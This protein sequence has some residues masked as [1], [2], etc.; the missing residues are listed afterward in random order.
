MSDITETDRLKRQVEM[1][2]RK[3]KRL[4]SRA[5]EKNSDEDSLVYSLA[6]LMTLLLI[7]FIL[8]YANSSSDAR[9]IF[10]SV[11]AFIPGL[12][13]QETN[14]AFTLDP[15][16]EFAPEGFQAAAEKKPDPK[17]DETPVSDPP[18]A[19]MEPVIAMLDEKSPA[20]APRPM[21]APAFPVLQGDAA[22]HVGVNAPEDEKTGPKNP[23]AGPPTARSTEKKP[24]THDPGLV[25]GSN[26]PPR[27]GPGVR[28]IQAPGPPNRPGRFR[29][30]QGPG[31]GGPGPGP[32]SKGYPPH[33]NP[34]VSRMDR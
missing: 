3:R 28:G 33:S 26:L 34:P 8:L 32:R 15:A 7:F 10:S 29:G 31:P 2:E 5:G 9:S 23:E 16:R 25:P 11:A 27:S 17:K 14:A 24:F 18:E 19:G 6:D 4:F 12:S 21:E 13:I 1:L 20:V 30:L 22:G